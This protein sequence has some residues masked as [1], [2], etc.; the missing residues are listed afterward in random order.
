VVCG[1]LVAVAVLATVAL[2]SRRRPAPSAASSTTVPPAPP[3]SV[4]PSTVPAGAPVLLVA[5]D[6]VHA[7][8]RV[9]SAA[10]NVD[11]TAIAPCWVEIRTSL[12]RGPIWYA[13]T[14]H[15]GGHQVVP[16]GV[17]TGGV[18]VRLGNPNGISVAVD[19]QPL[20]IPWPAGAQ[21][22]SLVLDAPPS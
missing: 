15:P 19:G 21:P 6:A 1:V 9:Q 18:S 2:L 22:F 12:G 14:L 8:Y 10:V 5:R 17:A 4:V 16:T 20:A 7:E 13:G 11:L 3:V